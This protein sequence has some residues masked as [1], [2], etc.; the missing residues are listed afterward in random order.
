MLLGGQSSGSNNNGAS[1]HQFTL[2]VSPPLPTK[3]PIPPLLLPT[4]ELVSEPSS[5]AEIQVLASI[6]ALGRQ[7]EAALAPT[8]RI[9]VG[10]NLTVVS[11]KVEQVSGSLTIG[12]PPT[13][14]AQ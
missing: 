9:V 6:E 13:I 2:N 11:S 8:K 3:S 1:T 7:E 4:E 12:D 14:C 5:T 10:H